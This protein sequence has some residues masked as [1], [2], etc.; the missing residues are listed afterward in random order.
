MDLLTDDIRARLKAN[1]EQGDAIDPPPYLK[2][3]C[4]W[5]A[6]TWL[7]TEVDPDGD[8]LFGLC[9][10][11]LGFPELGY[12]SLREIRSI[13]GPAGLVIERDIFWEPLASLGVYAEAARFS[14]R[15][16]ETRDDLEMAFRRLE[17]EAKKSGPKLKAR[18]L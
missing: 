7:F 16:T 18:M 17:R 14:E 9:D 12:A 4:P 3:F 11:G 8:T 5:G 13:Q 1:A 10:L 15:I 6:A 2:L